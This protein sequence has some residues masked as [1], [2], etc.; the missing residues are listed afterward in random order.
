MT[1]TPTEANPSVIRAQAVKEAH[2][3]ELLRKANV[4]GVGVGLRRRAGTMSREVAI[5]VLVRRKLPR[6]QLMP[7]D[8]VPAEIE[9]V[10]VDV[11]EVGEIRAQ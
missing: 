1:E 2:G 8:I 4:V 11:Q 3:P 5:V 6:A 10:P 9:G 7:E